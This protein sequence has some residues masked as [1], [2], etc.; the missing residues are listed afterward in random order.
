MEVSD[1]VKTLLGFA[2]KSGNLFSGE[3]A[4]EGCIKRNKAYL[5]LIADDFSEKRKY[6]YVKWFEDKGIPF[7]KIGSKAEC[8]YML[9]SSPRNLIAITDRQ[10][11]ETILRYLT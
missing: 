6:Y 4:V 9:G 3:K 8:G 10:I 5:I 2:K 1:K 11:A 7:L